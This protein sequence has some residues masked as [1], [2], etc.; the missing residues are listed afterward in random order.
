MSHNRHRKV[1]KHHLTIWLIILVIVAGA[2]VFS[3][4]RALPPLYPKVATVAPPAT[5]SN[6]IVWPNS[7][8]A[9][10]G[11]NGFSIL[12]VQGVQKQIPIASVA[13]LI[14][15][16][17][18]LQKYPLALSQ[19][20]TPVITLT[21]ADV[22]IYNQYVSEQ[23]SVVK[24][25]AGEQINEYQALEA[26]LIPSANNM[27]DSLAIWAFGS[28]P[29]YA[30]AANQYIKSIGLTQTTIGTDASGFLP[31]TTSTAHD[32][33]LIGFQA[34]NNPV[35]AQIVDQTQV[36]LPV[37]GVVKNY[38]WL[39]GT[40]GII[41]IKTG[42]T[43]QAGGVFVF[44]ASDKIVGSTTSNIQIVGS[45]E[46]AAT[47]QEALN[48]TPAFLNSIKDN[49]YSAPIIESHEIVGTYKIPWGDTIN[50]V[51]QNNISAPL[52]K[53]TTIRPIISLQDVYAPLNSDASVGVVD[54]PGQIT[55]TKSNIVLQQPIPAAPWWWR[56][57][58]HK[59]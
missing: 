24:V 8:E 4:T 17:T 33:I 32:L 31:A 3:Y 34:L 27:A 37:A 53:G 56:I 15:A 57:I 59:L 5:V 52:W 20:Q 22:A 50:A 9:A 30:T 48:D 54:V 45:I 1:A 6:P 16:L 19:L 36:T 47:L 18:I 23:G 13:K 26:M 39:L 11:A 43:N 7:Q 14:T 29:N 41:G 35:I 46:G 55:N 38:D 2:I 21:N 51:S 42:N 28:L 49:F 25:V 10:F 12:A 40:N 44:A 58:R